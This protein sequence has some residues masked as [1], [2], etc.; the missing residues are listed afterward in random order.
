MNKYSHTKRF[1]IS[2]KSY[3]NSGSCTEF[4]KKYFFNMAFTH[5]GLVCFIALAVIGGG[6][7]FQTLERHASIQKWYY[8]SI[9]INFNWN[10]N[11][12]TTSSE[13]GRELESKEITISLGSFKSRLTCF[14]N[15]NFKAF[16]KW[17][18]SNDIA[19]LLGLA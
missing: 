1:S 11:F 7:L 5:I 13:E 17:V 3:L 8:I 14:D 10:F 6:F 16:T 9:W 18:K 2:K 19:Y 15:L 4:D 12:C